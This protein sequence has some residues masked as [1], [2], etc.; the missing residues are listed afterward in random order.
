VR[1]FIGCNTSFR[2]EALEA[3]GGYDTH[4][5][6]PNFME[7]T[8]LC[9]RV[10]RAGWRVLFDPDAVVRHLSA[11][12]DT[13]MERRALDASLEFWTARS[14]AYF[15]LKLLPLSW[16][17]W[18]YNGPAF[19]VQHAREGLRGRQPGHLRALVLQAC[20]LML[21]TCDWLLAGC[22]R[23]PVETAG[24]CAHSPLSDSD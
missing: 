13:G 15:S 23:Q 2:R 20:G 8:D 3:A 21:G 12:R 1:H 6:G 22:P 17:V 11:P 7:E 10:G 9:L 24:P 5:G 4:Y 14:R 18:R 16:A 19:L